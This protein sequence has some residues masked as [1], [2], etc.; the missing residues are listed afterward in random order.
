VVASHSVDNIMAAPFN[1]FS[2][3][4]YGCVPLYIRFG[5][6]LKLGRLAGRQIRAHTAPLA[7]ILVVKVLRGTTISN[8][9]MYHISIGVEA[10]LKLRKS[11]TIAPWFTIILFPYV[12]VVRR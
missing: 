7:I 5:S 4:F 10:R 8:F 6:K 3:W 11:G 2:A 1:T 9:L 12:R